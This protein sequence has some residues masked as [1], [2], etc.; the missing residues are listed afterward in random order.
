MCD[1]QDM[2]IHGRYALAICLPA[3]GCVAP[4]SAE[5]GGDAA[6]GAAAILMSCSH[7]VGRVS[8]ASE[9]S[10]AD[11]MGPPNA[12]LPNAGGGGAAQGAAALLMSCSYLARSAPP[13]GASMLTAWTLQ[14][15]GCQ[16]QAE[17]AR[18]GAA[19]RAVA[20]LRKE[21]W[22]RGR[23]LQEARERERAL[24]AQVAGR[25]T[26]TRGLADQL[27]RAAQQARLPELPPPV[28]VD[29]GS[30]CRPS[31]EHASALVEKVCAAYLLNQR[32]LAVVM[33][34]KPHTDQLPYN[35]C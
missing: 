12:R 5:R 34:W 9:H 16:T 23:A 21:Q 31:R 2:H 7:L 22:R 35:A 25:R 20:A 30:T 6:H 14:A 15:L 19:E 26:H 4:R 27:A 33:S 10:H 1:A 8:L 17:A 3:G 29:S 28:T 11:G 13:Q 24:A 32:A 18:F